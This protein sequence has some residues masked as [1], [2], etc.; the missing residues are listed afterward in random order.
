MKTGVFDVTDYGS[1]EE[2]VNAASLV[3][4][5]V[6]F[7]PGEYHLNETLQINASITL[8]GAGGHTGASRIV[9]R[10]SSGNM[11]DVRGAGAVIRELQL[12]NEGTGSA[13]TFHATASAYGQILERCGISNLPGNNSH[14]VQFQGAYTRIADNI[15]GT[16]EPYAYALNC[17]KVADPA[18]FQFESWI[19]GNRMVG[20]GK[21]LLVDAAGM[22]GRPEGLRIFGNAIVNTGAEQLTIQTAFAVTVMGNTFGNGSLYAIW[23][24]DIGGPIHGVNVTG[25]SIDVASSIGPSGTP[26][27]D[28]YAGHSREGVAV[29]IP[30]SGHG[31]RNVNVNGNFIHYCGYGVTLG[32][33]VAN[34]GVVNNDFSSISHTGVASDMATNVLVMGNRFSGFV[35]A[36]CLNL[37]ADESH[38]VRVT[39]NFLSGHQL[40]SG[41]PTAPSF[42]YNL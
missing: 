23:L 24:R 5:I 18:V 36:F 4:G 16:N 32:A 37:M 9:G 27:T 35:N 8:L 7:P 38:H 26:N 30:G 22:G 25:N 20:P 33:N 28:Y 12:R 1:V 21:G 39:E 6:Y 41:S 11:M 34:V 19:T 13:I 2:A 29:N 42:G 31:V 17:H 14:L 40:N 3:G 10:Q 15:L